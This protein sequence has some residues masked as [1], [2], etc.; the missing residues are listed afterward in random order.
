MF[1]SKLEEIKKWYRGLPDKKRYVE[2]ITAILTVPVLMTVLI[3]NISNI[4]NNKR[5][6]QAATPAPLPTEKIIVITEKVDLNTPSTTP[7][8]TP[9]PTIVKQCQKVVGPVK[10]ASPNE[11]QLMMD[12]TVC[13][14]VA[15][16]GGDE[17]C[18]VVWSYRLDNGSWSEYTDKQICLLNMDPGPKALE[19]RV[20]SS[21]S[22]DE[23][24]LIR[25]FFYKT[26]DAPTPT[27]TTV[28]TSPAFTQ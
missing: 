12:N 2:F 16:Q 9:T 5:N 26:K 7:T 23:V 4:N 6:D 14:D 13:I 10:I 8:I 15:H 28:Q 24:T 11:G 1:K 25:N 21:Q 3:S 22:A 20:K 19:V 27:P 18:S 17:Y